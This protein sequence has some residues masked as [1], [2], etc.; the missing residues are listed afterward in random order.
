M[1]S[2]SGLI[3]GISLKDQAVF[4][5]QLATMIESGMPTLKSLDVLRNQLG[6]LLGRICGELM[7]SV[8]G[9][10]PLSAALAEHPE[11][12]SE[13]LVAMVHA[14]EV[15]GMMDVRL[16]EAADFLEES[17]NARQVLLSQLVYPV[18][19]MHAAVFLPPLKLLVLDGVQPYLAAVLPILA[20][21]YGI[22]AA[23]FV[24][25]RMGSVFPGPRAVMDAVLMLVPLLGRML[26]T[27]ALV[28]F[29]RAFGD[30]L[31]GGVATAE[32]L[33]VAARA[34]G[35]AVLERRLASAV[36]A[37]MAGTA[38]TVALGTTRVLP[39][40]TLQ[41]MSTG[42]ESGR[43]G[44]MLRKSAEFL[45]IEYRE[46]VKRALVVI[47]MLLLLLMGIVVGYQYIRMFAGIFSQINQ[48]NP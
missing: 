16:K 20:V 37:V 5:R 32:A 6:G 34:S 26:R 33:A 19:I 39:P 2:L 47:P 48:I 41:M 35:N 43:I 7:R 25:G 10:K 17:Y 4:F 31:E 23:L 40:A 28:R 22:G 24:V 11:Y 29:L 15:G 1:A 45:Q 14:G 21:F 27:A 46:A 18:V 8:D 9:G 36:P 3:L 38:I 42:E 44:A 30:L 12:F 13:F